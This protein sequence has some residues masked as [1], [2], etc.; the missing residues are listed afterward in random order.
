MK[1]EKLVNTPLPTFDKNYP[2]L[3]FSRIRIFHAEKDI[4]SQ[5]R[6]FETSGSE[7]VPTDR[8]SMCSAWHTNGLMDPIAIFYHLKI[9]S[10][11]KARLSYAQFL[12]FGLKF[13]V[14]PVVRKAE[15][16]GSLPEDEANY[17]NGRSLLN[18]ATG[19]SHGFGC[20]FPEGTSHSESHLIRLKTG[21]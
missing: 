20:L 7:K 1:Y 15:L 10:R 9:R 8:G 11:R 17:L 4:F 3:P 18:L 6:T 16:L 14:Q 12:G 21:H 13:A 2:V 5:F 19:I